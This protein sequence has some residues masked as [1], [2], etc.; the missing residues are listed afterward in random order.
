M[1]SADFVKAFSATGS[2]ATYAITGSPDGGYMMVGSTS[3][4]GAG[5]VDILL[6][7]LDRWGNFQWAKTL[8]S[9]YKDGAADIISTSDANFLIVGTTR[10][11]GVQDDGVIVLKVD[12]LGN[13]IWGKAIWGKMYDWGFT[14]IELSDG[15]YL[16]TGLTRSFGTYGPHLMHIKLSF[17]G[18][19]LWSRVLSWDSNSGNFL[20]ESSDGSFFTV[21]SGPIIVVKSDSIGLPI[22][23]NLI[24]GGVAETGNACQELPS[25]N[26]LVLGSTD[27][28]FPYH[29]EEATI[30]QTDIMV[31]KL[32]P[33]G[34]LIWAK[35][36]GTGDTSSSYRADDAARSWK[37]LDDGTA[38]I[39]ANTRGEGEG[40]TDQLFI[41]IDT[42]GNVLWS[43]T[44]GSEHEDKCYELAMGHKG[45]CVSVGYT[46]SPGPDTLNILATMFNING[47][48]C[49]AKPC[50]LYIANVNPSV[51]HPVPGIS[52][53]T[54]SVADV[55]PVYSLV[56]LEQ[57]TWCEVIIPDTG[58]DGDLGFWASGPRIHF[59]IPGD[60]QVRVSIYNVDGVL[61]E[62]PLDGFLEGG[63]Y[64]LNLALPVPGIYFVQVLYGGRAYNFKTFVEERTY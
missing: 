3:S 23:I 6:V 22:W 31:S 51:S 20:L 57:Y 50:S 60:G 32:D 13:L 35:I 34:N 17:T 15:G 11:F 61:V 56:E 27:S 54:W 63:S 26:I 53:P 48:N 16:I 44:V 38:I 7:K 55:A 28:Y 29:L 36:M 1:Y 14:G 33:Q 49:K 41:K 39:A 19:L 40:G 37:T 62:R 58:K 5:S 12:T 24:T 9:P 18:Q 46:K 10:G 2:E 42:C 8:G 45:S 4:F 30:C 59:E 64:D 47:E 43:F 25:G 52:T 21:G